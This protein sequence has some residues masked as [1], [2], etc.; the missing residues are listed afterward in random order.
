MRADLLL[1][2]AELVRRSE[3]FALATVVRRQPPSSAR[4]GDT[5]LIT[6]GGACHGWVGGTCTQSG[7]VR[8]A[9]RVLREGTPA[10]IVARCFHGGALFH[11]TLAVCL[12]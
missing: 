1:L 6:R 3:P 4:E 2:A 8:E 7:V 5:A 11:R 10:A 12:W 9:M